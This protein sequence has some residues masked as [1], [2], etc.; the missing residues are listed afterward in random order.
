VGKD[1]VLRGGEDRVY[2]GRTIGIYLELIPMDYN[3]KEIFKTPEKLLERSNELECLFESFNSLH[4]RVHATYPELKE[5]HFLIEI[6]RDICSLLL[7]LENKNSIKKEESVKTLEKIKHV[8]AELEFKN[9]DELLRIVQDNRQRLENIRPFSIELSKAGLFADG[10][11]SGGTIGNVITAT[12]ANLIIEPIRREVTREYTDDKGQL[13]RDTITYNIRRKDD[14]NDNSLPIHKETKKLK[15]IKQVPID[16]AN[17]ILTTRKT[18]GIATPL[19]S[20][21]ITI[22]FLRNYQE[23]KIEVQ[24]NKDWREM[25]KFN[26]AQTGLLHCQS[27]DPM[28]S[29]L[30]RLLCNL[31]TCGEDGMPAPTGKNKLDTRRKQGAFRVL[32]KRHNGKIKKVFGIS[33]DPIIKNGAGNYISAIKLVPSRT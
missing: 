4:K 23:I 27:P 25:G 18:A 13:V 24:I 22:Y 28:K 11:M 32:I 7:P 12:M 14:D 8:L 31:A 21:E 20:A 6:K 26:P 9:A 10:G 17:M 15:P 1:K 19:T 30:W 5:I 2:M 16:I 3:L 29:K 33:D